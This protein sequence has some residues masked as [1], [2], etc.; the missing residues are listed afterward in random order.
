M[1]W[2]EDKVLELI[3]IYKQYPLLWKP[4]DP[5]HFNKIKKSDAWKDIG[6]K[7]LRPAEE[8]KKKMIYLLSS[9]RREKGK[10]KNSTGTG[11]GKFL[12]VN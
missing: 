6:D 7:M 5:Q 2:S 10:V 9:Y 4:S 3:E 12:F 1:E 11:T 8:C